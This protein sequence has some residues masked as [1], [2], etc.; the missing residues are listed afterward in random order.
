MENKKQ[1]LVIPP[2]SEPLQKLNEVLNGIATDENIEI[3][4][5]DDLKELGQFIGSSGQCLVAFSNAKKCATFLQENRFAIAKTHTKV[6]LLTPKEIPA[7]TLVKFTKI[8]LTESILE[9][10]P[11]KTLLYKVKLLLRSIKSSGGSEEKELA[12]KT[13]G[14]TG[15]AQAQSK[16]EMN[17][18]K[19]QT[20]E[21][22]VNYLAEERAK[23]KKEQEE[24][25]AV[26]YGE[27][28]KG[29]PTEQEEA[30][31]TH[32]KSKRKK[33]EINHEDAEP[34]YSKVEVEDSEDIDMYYRGKKKSNEL[35]IIAGEEVSKR[36]RNEELPEEEDLIGKKINTTELDLGPGEK[37]KRQKL[38]EDESENY[39]MK[40]TSDS[41]TLEAAEEKPVQKQLTE[42]EEE[43]IKRKEMLELEALFEEA[44]KRQEAQAAEVLGGHYKGKLTGA[45][46]DEDEPELKEEKKEY[47]N[48][49]LY[50]KEKSFELDLEPA[51]KEEKRRM[52]E[53][54]VDQEE[55]ERNGYGEKID[56]N[57]SS[58]EGSTDHIETMMKGGLGKDDSKNISTYDTVEKKRTKEEMDEEEVEP[59]KKTKLDL[60]SADVENHKKKLDNEENEAAE[61][62]KSFDLNLAPGDS[63]GYKREK[64]QDDDKE[65]S[66]REAQTKLKLLDGDR[67]DRKGEKLEVEDDNIH[68]KKLDK[69]ELDI[70]GKKERRA[71]GRVDKIDTFYRS[72]ES[73]KKEHDWDLEEKN[74]NINLALDKV[75]RR[76]PDA[77]GK[78]ES[79]DLGEQTI[80]YRRLK[81]EFDAISR[82]GE[83]SD[84]G[85]GSGSSAKAPGEE[86]EDSSFKVIEID[87]AG[88]DFAIEVLNM[89]YQ[90]ELK[91]ED[92]Y[93][94]ISEE[95]LSTYHAYPVFYSYKPNDKKHIESYD[96][97][98]KAP[99]NAENE[100]VK[101]WWLEH[102]K[103]EAVLTD[104]QSKT[105]ATWACREMSWEDV[106]LPTWA[107]NE[108]RTKKVELIYPYYDGVDRMGLAMV[109]FPDGLNP[110]HA[111]GI[112]V[113]LEMARTLMLDIVQRKSAPVSRE[114]E[115]VTEEASEKKNILNVFS[116][117]FKGKKAG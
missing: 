20:E 16:G 74:K 91:P 80:D 99:L 7:K 96:S 5:I 61:R 55:K 108:L 70:D 38:R 36:K 12:V 19:L 97:I 72:G 59:T 32:W 86:G 90:K 45:G 88:F 102:K 106:E 63:E 11:P 110:K 105:M 73:K 29:K 68:Y 54:E 50:S 17:S 9:N 37:E 94:A 116:G 66:E 115:P 75:A 109:Y 98:L 67:E 69:T 77:V 22:S 93:K 41:F 15:A 89:I 14:D 25:E 104:A 79:V 53:E 49:D 27:N 101:N 51:E 18:D 40:K 87:P 103:D 43:E 78:K 71:D 83:S 6:I 58:D 52:Q 35:D 31:D 39:L 112:E 84:G 57:M 92:F 65:E 48:S 26:N 3:S 117:F 8:G 82:G 34:D 56:E 85:P 76:G 30:I 95:L 33:D 28:L 47:D 24:A 60:A 1:L 23:F 62:E 113:T 13:M 4:I 111:K 44:K 114:E 100:A 10:S 2:M 21:G 107:E 81:E 42:E 46:L 64:L